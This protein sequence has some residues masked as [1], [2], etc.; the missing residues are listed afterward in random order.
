MGLLAFA[1]PAPVICFTTHGTAVRSRVRP[2]SWW[3]PVIGRRCLPAWPPCSD[4]AVAF[5]A[6]PTAGDVEMKPMWES[7]SPKSAT[8][9]AVA[10]TFVQA[11]MAAAERRP[12]PL[13]AT[14]CAVW[15]HRY[16]GA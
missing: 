6:V 10:Y 11:S 14:C 16:E 5:L 7:K 4:A 2:G 15:F 9:L 3:P 8:L 12:L 1:A 13:A